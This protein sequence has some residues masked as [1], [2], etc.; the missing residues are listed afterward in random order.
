ML[1]IQGVTLS[2][3]THD[4]IHVD[5]R[6]ASRPHGRPDNSLGGH[7]GDCLDGRHDDR[8]EGYSDAC[9]DDRSDNRRAS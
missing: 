3:A 1:L 4:T 6:P 8:L 9:L 7:P 2:Y 5:G